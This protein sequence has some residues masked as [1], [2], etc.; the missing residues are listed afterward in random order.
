VRLHN[1]IL[2]MYCKKDIMMILHYTNNDG[3]CICNHLN[4]DPKPSMVQVLQIEIKQNRAC[5]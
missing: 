3:I 2:W 5:P 4:K 1:I